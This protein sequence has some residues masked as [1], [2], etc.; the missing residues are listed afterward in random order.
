MNSKHI[1][2]VKEW[3]KTHL[4]PYKDTHKE[5]YNL[6]VNS[7]VIKYSLTANYRDKFFVSK[8][9]R[10]YKYLGLNIWKE[11]PY[12]ITIHYNG[13]KPKY[14][15]YVYI[16][17]KHI[18]LSRLVASVWVKKLKP[19]YNV[20]MH[21]DDDRL[22]NKYTNI[23]WGTQSQNVKMSV[24]KGHYSKIHRDRRLSIEQEH[25][26]LEEYKSGKFSQRKLAARWGFSQSGI[27]KIIK[28]NN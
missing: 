21:L 14:Y 13:I 9:G 6:R 3:S 24:K 10:V 8:R 12:S 27:Q 22:N 19:S 28:R 18:S 23:Q 11:V 16:N 2:K 17:R 5:Y 7:E 1:S 20:V 4:L 26:L 15:V 25:K